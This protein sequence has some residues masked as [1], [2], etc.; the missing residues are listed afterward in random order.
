[1][2]EVPALHEI[3]KV[4][5]QKDFNKIVETA[6]ADKRLNQ[7]ERGEILALI[8]EMNKEKQNIHNQAIQN[9]KD[10]AKTYGY[11][12]FQAH[13]EKSLNSQSAAV[14]QT[15]EIPV[16]ESLSKDEA[17]VSSE[18]SPS[19]EPSSVAPWKSF[20]SSS[21]EEISFI[22]KTGKIF[23]SGV[24]NVK[25]MIWLSPLDINTLPPQDKNIVAELQKAEFK[26]TPIEGKTSTYEVDMLWLGE[27]SILS[28][29]NNGKIKFLTNRVVVDGKQ[30]EFE[31]SDVKEAKEKLTQINEYI[32]VSFEIKPLENIYET[33]RDFSQQDRYR[34]LSNR[35][36]AL[37]KDLWIIS[38]S[39]SD[40]K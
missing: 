3:P 34:E 26:L 8:K 14:S 40:S 16:G 6:L 32:K 20:S 27:K 31:F 15:S 2:A 28:I 13:L 4:N 29:E 21:P 7:K 23:K 18:S 1:M 25:N 33:Q 24:D 37:E 11:T 22:D 30:K 17:L 9:L 10:F 12:G 39:S 5:S 38:E 19:Q 35:K 36:G